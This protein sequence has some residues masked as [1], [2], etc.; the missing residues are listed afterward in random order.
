MLDTEGEGDFGEATATLLSSQ[1]PGLL[2]EE[3]PL[4]GGFGAGGGLGGATAAAPGMVMV[5]A[6]REVPFPGYM[7]A[8][9]AVCMITVGLSGAMMYDLM[10]SMWSW[11]EPYAINS[12]L[13]DVFAGK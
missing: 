4:G 2:E 6:V 8:L 10:R 12:Q 13:M 5:P 11:N 7:V 9:L 3:S 1:I